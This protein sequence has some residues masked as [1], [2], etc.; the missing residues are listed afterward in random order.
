MFWRELAVAKKLKS[1]IGFSDP[2][3]FALLLILCSY[4]LG[5]ILT[6]IMTMTYYCWQS[7]CGLPRRYFATTTWAV[8]QTRPMST[9]SPSSCR[10]WSYAAIRSKCSTSPTKVCSSPLRS[11][12]RC[13]ILSLPLCLFVCLSVRGNS[14]NA[15][16]FSSLDRIGRFLRDDIQH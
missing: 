12:R 2:S 7:C 6:T 11:A 4:P 14:D 15:T 5:C 1:H 16:T 13:I 9:V 3:T 8:L 10:K